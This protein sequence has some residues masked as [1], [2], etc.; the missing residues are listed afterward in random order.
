MFTADNFFGNDI[1]L[2]NKR[3]KLTALNAD[4]IVELEKIAY[5][6]SLWKLGMSNIKAAEDLKDYIDIALKERSSKASYPFLI[7]DKQTNSVTGSTRYG[8]ISFP[9]KRLEIGWTWI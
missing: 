7:F 3:A 6:P 9:H 4:D 2:E 1:M 8:N 5:E